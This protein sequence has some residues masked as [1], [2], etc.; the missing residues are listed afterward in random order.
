MT[1]VP[2]DPPAPRRPRAGYGRWIVAGIAVVVAVAVGVVLLFGGEADSP[3]RGPLGTE[4]IVGM[5]VP[6]E[7]GRPFSIG[8]PVVYNRGDEPATIDRISLVE[9][10]PGIEVL[11]THVAGVDR[12]ILLNAFTYDW[13][14]P[15]D[16]SDL[17]PP[18]GY[19]VPPERS[20]DG[21]RGVELV[22][23]LEV[24]GPGPHRFTGAQVDYSIGADAYRTVLWEGA[25]ICGVRTLPKKVEPDCDALDNRAKT[26]D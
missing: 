13:P 25:R 2:A 3:P 24:D 19:V 5:G 22:F 20:E 15:R 7:I 10:S 4:S 11:E 6:Q 12:D 18:R 17:H 1:T 21:K 23:V 9:K 14:A 26:Y 16:Y 8:L